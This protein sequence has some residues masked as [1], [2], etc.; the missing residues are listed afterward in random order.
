MKTYDEL[1][2]DIKRAVS[3]G[4]KFGYRNK[5]YDITDLEGYV[6]HGAFNAY[7]YVLDR[8]EEIREADDTTQS[9]KKRDTEMK[10]ERL[11][12][13]RCRNCFGKLARQTDLVGQKYCH[14]CGQ[15]LDWTNEDD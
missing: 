3:D 13:F 5:P 1:Y 7:R 10:P 15:K 11:D 4:F 2:D 8:L 12:G 14:H 6:N 9:I